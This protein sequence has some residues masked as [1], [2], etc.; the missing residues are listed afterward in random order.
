MEATHD[1]KQSKN[2]GMENGRAQG[3]MGG[4]TEGHDGEHREVQS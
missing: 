1:E 4:A 3:E 2:S